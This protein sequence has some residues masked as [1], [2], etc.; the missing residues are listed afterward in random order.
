LGVVA[1]ATAALG[2][3]KYAAGVIALLLILRWPIQLTFGIYAFLIP[4][5]NVTTIGAEASG[6]TL[7]RYVGLAVIF[8]LLTFGLVTRRLSVPPRAAL[9]WSLFV[10]W[11]ALTFGWALDQQVVLQKVPIACSLLL[12]YLVASSFRFSSKELA[13]V[14]VMAVLGACAGALLATSSFLSGASF[15]GTGRSSLVIAGRESDPNFFSDSLVL[16]LSL[17]VG[18]LIQARRRLV[19]AGA[20]VAIV[21]LG[22]A[23]LLT[24]SRGGLLATFTVIFVYVY[25]L[26]VNRRIILATACILLLAMLMPNSFFER[27]TLF[28]RG[29]PR[30]DIW[31]ASLGLLPEHG[32]LGAGL[33]NFSI[34]YYSVAGNASVFH[35]LIRDA[36]NIYLGIAVEV[37][38]VGLTFL[39]LAF[40]EQLRHAGH[41]SVL[42]YQAACWGMLAAGL[43]LDV[44]FRKFFWLCWI[45]L[46]ISSRVSSEDVSDGSSRQLRTR[47]P[48]S[49]P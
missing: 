47:P 43:T 46:A 4:F 28:D 10:F 45:L 13:T 12:L 16:A 9:W 26:K 36:H 25:R 39:F 18:A 17:S 35:G 41:Y 34:A 24:M 38:I 27:V 20:L 11:A 19:R 8:V 40:R 31:T 1:G 30:L 23:Q 33:G 14:A 2:G 42:P 37:G 6:A 32:L 7:S 3:W 29:G 48:A 21:I 5:D 44:M 15:H 22:L 49:C